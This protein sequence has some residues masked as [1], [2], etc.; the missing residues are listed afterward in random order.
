MKKLPAL[1]ALALL[2]MA[3]PAKSLGEMYNG[4]MLLKDCREFQKYMDDN[5][6]PSIVMSS[7]GHCL[8]YLQGHIDFQQH[9]KKNSPS[10]VK[11]CFPVY[12]TLTQLGK[13]TVKYLEDNPDKLNKPALDIALAA[14]EES[15]PCTEPLSRSSK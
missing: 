15:F 6:D 1:I 5:E 10:E 2:L 14:F 11:H 8:G 12:I 4:Y 3:I 7:I 13:I 9:L